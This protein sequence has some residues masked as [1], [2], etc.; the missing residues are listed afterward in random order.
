MRTVASFAVS[1][2][3]F[4]IFGLASSRSPAPVID[5]SLFRSPTYALANVATFVFSVAFTAMF[6]SLILFQTQV[7][8]YSIL[9]AGLGI[10]PG[11]LMV[12]PTAILAG[13]YA[14]RRGHR[15]EGS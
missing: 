12:I 11:P 1:A 3:A 8:G 6:F 5:L 10:T 4:A 2:I 15:P 14:A 7:W 9:E 13:R